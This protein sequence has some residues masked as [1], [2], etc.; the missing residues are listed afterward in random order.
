MEGA[1]VFSCDY[2]SGKK[3][4]FSKSDNDLFLRVE[5]NKV[6]GRG[7]VCNEDGK[8]GYVDE[9]EIRISEMGNV[10]AGEYMNMD[11]LIFEGRITGLYG[12]KKVKIAFPRM[13][14]M[15]LVL[16]LLKR[17]KNS[18][19]SAVEEVQN[20]RAQTAQSSYRAENPE[21]AN[22]YRPN[23]YQQEPLQQEEQ[24]AEPEVESREA[25]DGE[26]SNEE[27]QKRME[28]LT[29]LKDCGLLGEKEFVAKKIELVS[30]FCDLKDFNDK[31][32]KLIV[33]KDCGMLS[34]K[35]FEANRIDIIKEC[36]N[37]ST[38]DLKE[39]RRNVQ[40]L[41]FLEMGGVISGEEYEKNKQILLNDVEFH[42]DDSKEL[43][44]RK[45]KRLP[46]LKEC[47]LI[48]E[49]EYKHRMDG[50]LRMIEVTASE[51]LEKLVDK[52]NK[53][54]V[55]A[56]EKVISTAELKEKQKDLIT[57]YISADWHTPEELETVAR[58]MIALKQ[59]EWLTDSEYESRR[60]KLLR[61]VETT[62]DY[63][64]KLKIYMMLRKTNFISENDYLVQKQK[65]I[66]VIFKASS[67]VDEFKVRVNNLIEMQKIGMISEEE[68]VDFKAKLMSEL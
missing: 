22:A 7:Y 47:Q 45:L 63:S 3:S 8:N 68:F 28:K 16:G 59:G 10:F 25:D 35:E 39:Y 66:D 13:R 21:T 19:G 37:T 32:Q 53:W 43:F 29:V 27:F 48:T 51:P 52:L 60:E 20:D 49:K 1:Q 31:I 56:Q 57:N 15:N 2:S 44:S 26:R 12:N 64:T 36:C 55:L 38:T 58:N 46:I 41:S 14:N 23:A 17:L 67:S 11:A 5:N 33:L 4:R 50:M 54:P 62:A 61:Q 40:K 9:F 18:S 34:E 42:V 30:E 6:S 65:C 24:F